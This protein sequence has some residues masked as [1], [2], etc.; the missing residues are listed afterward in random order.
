MLWM[1]RWTIFRNIAPTGC[2]VSTE[3]K[4]TNS[5][6]IKKLQIA[7]IKERGRRS[8]RLTAGRVRPE[9]EEKWPSSLT[10]RCR[11][12]H[13]GD[14]YYCPPTDTYLEMFYFWFRFPFT[15]SVYHFQWKIGNSVNFKLIYFSS[16]RNLICLYMW[17]KELHCFKPSIKLSKIMPNHVNAEIRVRWGF[18]YRYIICQE[19]R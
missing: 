4:E 8:E 1:N 2:N 13:H 10:F 3:F 6:T 7:C 16:S 5:G 11:H 9:R 14:V 12:H 19:L 18:T 15:F 17:F